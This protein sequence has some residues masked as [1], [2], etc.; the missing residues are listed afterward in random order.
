MAVDPATAAAFANTAG[1]I[2]GF[3]SGLFKSK[4]SHA[5]STAIVSPNKTGTGVIAKNLGGP[6][7]DIAFKT[8]R[9][10]AAQINSKFKGQK[11]PFR[12]NVGIVADANY[13][14]TGGA[15]YFLTALPSAIR[16]GTAY[17][18]VNG[19][20]RISINSGSALVSG[21]LS[22]VNQ[23][24]P[25]KPKPKP[26]P[27]PVVKAPVKQDNAVK[28]Q[29]TDQTVKL[30]IDATGPVVIN[31]PAPTPSLTPALLAAAAYYLS[32]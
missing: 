10:L 28:S 2:G 21:V 16:R 9:T 23:K 31:Q 19:R 12:G 15:P 17:A 11:L 26:K 3:L 25:N 27:K 20:N 4:P 29:T 7:G 32:R 1:K 18:D 30:P 6:G 22:L 13:Q 14:K 8:A 5:P 24:F